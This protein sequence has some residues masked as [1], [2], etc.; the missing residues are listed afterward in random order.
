MHASNTNT[1]SSTK[2]RNAFGR[3]GRPAKRVMEPT[4]D[5]LFRYRL[6]LRI[7]ATRKRLGLTQTELAVRL[8]VSQG[9]INGYETGRGMPRTHDLPALCRALHTDPNALLEFGNE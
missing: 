7:R 3:T 6:A 2:I 9:R 5:A 1:R 8:R 4:E